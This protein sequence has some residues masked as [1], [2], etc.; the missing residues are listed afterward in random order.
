MLSV[1]SVHFE[2]S[3]DDNKTG[4]GYR[5]TRTGKGGKK[6]E[7]NLMMVKERFSCKALAGKTYWC[8]G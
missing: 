6:W 1:T 4:N 5:G 8:F 3:P 2:C 7:Q